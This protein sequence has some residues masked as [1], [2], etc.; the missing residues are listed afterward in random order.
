MSEDL[1]EVDGG[2]SSEDAAHKAF[3]GEAKVA[4]K[5]VAYYDRQLHAYY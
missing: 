1:I 4:L 3:P 5:A 2:E